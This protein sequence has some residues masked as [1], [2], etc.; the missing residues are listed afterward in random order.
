MHVV[1]PSPEHITEDLVAPSPEP[2]IEEMGS[3]SISCTAATKTKFL[4]KARKR[5]IAGFGRSS[6]SKGSPTK[7][8]LSMVP[9]ISMVPK[10]AATEYRSLTPTAAETAT[11]IKP[12]N[13]NQP[14]T[15]RN[16]SPPIRSRSSTGTS[17]TQSYHRS[18]SQI[19][20]KNP[21]GSSGDQPQRSSSLRR[22]SLDPGPFH[23]SSPR[24]SSLSSAN[25]AP[26]PAQHERY[27]SPNR[28]RSS[29]CSGDQPQRSSHLRRPS[30]DPGPVHQSSPRISSFSSTNAATATT[31]IPVKPERGRSPTR[32]RSSDCGSAASDASPPLRDRVNLRRQK[33]VFRNPNDQPDFQKE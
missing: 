29:D 16:F 6:D 2:I 27:R 21:T 12:S 4:K 32:G 28:D 11:R 19:D 9:K 14:P 8:T 24:I 20:N 7:S 25:A 3:L 5:L 30:L 18:T 23:Q 33:K 17:G 26:I 13:A 31:T 1:A 15:G 22:P 10:K